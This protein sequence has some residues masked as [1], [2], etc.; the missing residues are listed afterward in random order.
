M[1]EAAREAERRRP[2]I[3]HHEAAHAVFAYH[4]GEPIA[5]VMVGEDSESLSHFRYE[6]GDPAST[7]KVVAGIL[8]GKYAEELAATGKPR[9][10]IPYEQF[11]KGIDEGGRTNTWPA[12]TE[13][14]EVQAFVIL[15]MSLGRQRAEETYRAAS[16]YAAE[17]VELWWGEIDALAKRLLEHGRVEGSEV[18]SLIETAKREQR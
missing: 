6:R 1:N 7:T 18:R 5:H 10:H 8:A 2:G 14:D 17:H 15:R 9:Q 3:C 4:S 12:G 11:V 13:A 16:V